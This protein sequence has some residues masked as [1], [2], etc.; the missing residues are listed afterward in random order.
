MTGEVVRLP[1]TPG[2]FVADSLLEEQGFE[3]SVPV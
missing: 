3:P 2:R 1:S